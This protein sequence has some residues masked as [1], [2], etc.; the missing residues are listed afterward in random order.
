MLA[1]EKAVPVPMLFWRQAQESIGGQ[2]VKTIV[3]ICFNNPYAAPSPTLI[4]SICQS[5][6]Y[7]HFLLRDMD[8]TN[9]RKGYIFVCPRDKIQNELYGLP[10]YTTT[11]AV[12]GQ[13]TY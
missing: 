12:L 9:P 2:P 6:I 3:V 13:D 4:Q 8:V 5:P 7:D 1:P 11:P 10:R